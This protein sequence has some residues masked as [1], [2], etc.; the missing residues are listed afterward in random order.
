MR[1]SELDQLGNG[2][3]KHL[4]AAAYHVLGFSA[5]SSKIRA[6]ADLDITDQADW[7]AT[8]GSPPLRD[9]AM[10][11]DALLAVGDYQRGAPPF[12]NKS[13]KIWPLTAGIPLS[14]PRTG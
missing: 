2:G 10:L 8:F 5:T 1:E 4:L 13:P 7:Q 6:T 9:R 11:L 12:T 3:E 14:P